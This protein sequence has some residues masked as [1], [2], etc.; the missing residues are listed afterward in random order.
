MVVNYRE[1]V[2]ESKAT[3]ENLYQTFGVPMNDDYT[4]VVE[5]RDSEAWS[6]MAR[7]SY[8]AEEFGMHASKMH[9]EL[10][11]SYEDYPWT[12]QPEQAANSRSSRRA[13]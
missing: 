6:H 11:D 5:A 10:V 1:L 7:Y 8:S 3:I 12:P 4:E 9:R 13:F 2:T